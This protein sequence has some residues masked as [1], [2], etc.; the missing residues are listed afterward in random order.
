M[1][2]APIDP[3]TAAIIEE[4][5]QRIEILEKELAEKDRRIAELEKTAEEQ[6][7]IIEEWK[8]GHRVRPKRR[9]SSSKKRK[10]N[11]SGKKRPGRKKGHE[12]AQ[13]PMPEHTDREEQRTK[14]ECDSCHG[15][16]RPTGKTKEVVVEHVIPARVEVEKNI[17]YEYVCSCCGEVQWSELPP[18][19]GPAPPP[20]QP[21]LG[22]G[23]LSLALGLR[24]GMGLSFHRIAKYFEHYVG[25]KITA[26]GLYQMIERAARRTKVVAEEILEQALM[27]L[28][29]NMDETTWWEDGKKLWAWLM[30]NLDLSY[31]H[32]EDSRSHEVIEKLLCER[33]EEGEVI[34]PYEGTV[35]SDFMGA[36]RT[37]A[38][39]VHQWCWIHLLRD[40]DKE[41]ELA[42]CRRTE[43]FRD[44]LHDIYR[45]ALVAQ[46]TQDEGTKHGIRVRLGRLV[47]DG[48]LG[49]HPDVARLQGRAYE[50]F[51]GLLHFLDV[52][53]LPPHNNQGELDIRSLVLFRKVIFGTRSERG[54]EVHAH[55]MSL[56]Q[57]A[58]KQG[59]DLGDFVTQATAAYMSGVPPP[60]IFRS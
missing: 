38:W 21:L 14:E 22:P 31:F 58:R 1:V 6:S 53:E 4:Q 59:I 11:P 41:A 17:L 24:Y 50:E 48:D 51:H 15:G 7:R 10:K 2:V 16:L 49:Q 37:C 60:S 33:D 25:L 47:A 40:A 18:E 26:G 5:Q 54:T 13:R 9:S 36:Y 52:P 12:A 46:Q 23:V 28:Y 45:N 43:A 42:P 57:T 55:F 30:A 34:A 39:M 20:G 35:I 56:S 8:R 3:A 27:S 32:I 29:L 19:Y 44:R